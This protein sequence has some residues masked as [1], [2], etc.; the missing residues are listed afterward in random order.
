MLALLCELF[1][2]NDLLMAVGLRKKQKLSNKEYETL[3]SELRSVT[4]HIRDRF[5][6]IIF[7]TE[8][9]IDYTQKLE[10]EL[11]DLKQRHFFNEKKAT[12]STVAE[13]YIRPQKQ[14]SPLPLRL[15]LLYD[16]GKYASD[17]WN[18][19]VKY[20]GISDEEALKLA[21]GENKDHGETTNL[22][23]G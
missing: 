19:N 12:Q 22:L 10:E 20:A 9:Y 3:L 4:P 14:C 18:R 15:K 21:K 5:A 7:H 17:D 6:K 23:H 11:R 2:F 8:W 1:N 13:H 16:Q